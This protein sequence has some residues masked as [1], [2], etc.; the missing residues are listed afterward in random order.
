MKIFDYSSSRDA[1]RSRTWKISPG[2]TQRK[3]KIKV[4]LEGLTHLDRFCH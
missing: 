1:A 4:R 3:D 2:A